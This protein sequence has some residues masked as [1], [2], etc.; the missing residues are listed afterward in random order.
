[1]TVNY[2]TLGSFDVEFSNVF[3]NTIRLW[4]INLF[5]TAPHANS[6]HVE[7]LLAANMKEFCV[8]ILFDSVRGG[9]K[10]RVVRS[11]EKCLD[12]PKIGSDFG[13]HHP[14]T[15]YSCKLT[16]INWELWLV[17][18]QSSISD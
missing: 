1:M 18:W 15:H 2:F 10:T 6:D 3:V 5:P 7:K 14:R 8:E 17:Y 11:L 16:S 9:C 13:E 4:T 12:Y